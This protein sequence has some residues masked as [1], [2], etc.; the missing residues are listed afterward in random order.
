[1]NTIVVFLSTLPKWQAIGLCLGTHLVIVALTIFVIWFFDINKRAIEMCDI[2]GSFFFW[3]I[4]WLAGATQFISMIIKSMF[5]DHV[6]IQRRVTKE[7][8]IKELVE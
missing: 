4:L 2:W 5:S 1:M 6:V 7:R 3:P 8:M